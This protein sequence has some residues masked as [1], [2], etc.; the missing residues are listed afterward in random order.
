[1]PVFL[2]SLAMLGAVLLWGSSPTVNKWVLADVGVSEIVAFRIVGAGLV[3]WLLLVALRRV[4]WTGPLP[5]VMGILEPGLVTSFLVLGLSHTSA[6]NASVVWG[7]MPLSQPLLGRLVLKE[8]IERPV[9]IG[10]LLAI[11]GTALLVGLTQ[12]DGTGSLLGDLFLVLSVLCA[13][14]NQLIARRVAI[15]VRDPALTTAYQ[16]LSASLVALTVL[17]FTARPAELYDGVTAP[18]F[19]WL[20]Y[21][22]VTTG[23]PFLLYNYTLQYM[24]VGKV[25]LFAPLT[26]PIG[27][28]IA[29]LV[30][31]EPLSPLILAAIAMALAGA[32][33]PAWAARR[34]RET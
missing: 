32:F 16:L 1:M 17:L 20:A 3:L 22:I 7:I 18:T 6:V 2:P 19:L 14:S 24:P 23:G 31:R 11:G 21:L 13:G 33:L 28:L 25:S 26:G 8:P 27:I 15:K 34:K 4:R 9:M 30:F 29:T 12:G 5:L 10:A